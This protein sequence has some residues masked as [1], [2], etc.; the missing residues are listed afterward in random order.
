MS[1]IGQDDQD[2]NPSRAGDGNPAITPD[3]FPLTRRRAECDFSFR[4]CPLPS[5]PGTKAA[6]VS[7]RLPRPPTH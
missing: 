5:R 2:A 1:R 3:P 4:G 6:F 7:L